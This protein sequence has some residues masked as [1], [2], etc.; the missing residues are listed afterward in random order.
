MDVNI[1]AW[2]YMYCDMKLAVKSVVSYKQEFSLA[3]YH[4]FFSL[5][6]LIESQ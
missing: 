2:W 3:Q 1:I 6:Y 5:A 4:Y